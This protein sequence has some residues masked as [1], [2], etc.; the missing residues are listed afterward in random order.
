M[1]TATYE[2]CVETDQPLRMWAREW[3]ARLFSEETFQHVNRGRMVTRTVSLLEN[4]YLIDAYCDGVWM[5]GYV[6]QE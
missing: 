5:S 4:G 3:S 6:V 1:R 2:I